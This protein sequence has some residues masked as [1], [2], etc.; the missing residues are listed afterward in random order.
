[1][2]LARLLTKAGRF[3]EAGRVFEGLIADQ[4]AR[5]RLER[6]G[7]SVDTL[8]ADWGWGLVDAEKTSEADQVFGRLL[9][10][11]PNSPHAGDARFNLAESANLSRNYA[12][13]IRLLTPL[14]DSKP[15]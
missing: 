12:E 8:L 1:M 6:S 11:F 13:V 9:K 2:L 5:S 10:E 15:S 4:A 3:P 14:A 7:T